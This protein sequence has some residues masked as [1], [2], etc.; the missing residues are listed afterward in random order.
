MFL[1]TQR[2]NASA[3]NLETLLNQERC[4]R[5]EDGSSETPLAKARAGKFVEVYKLLER[6]V[7][8][9]NDC[10]RKYTLLHQAVFWENRFGVVTLINFGA[11]V[12]CKTL[13]KDELLDLNSGSTPLHIAALLGNEAILRLL[14]CSGADP[15]VRDDCGLTPAQLN[16][17][18]ECRTVLQDTRLM[19][20]TRDMCNFA[21]VQ[22]INKALALSLE[23]RLPLDV[24]AYPGPQGSDF[25]IIHQVAFFGDLHNY[26]ILLAHGASPVLK[27]LGKDGGGRLLPSAVARRQNKVAE[28][29]EMEVEERRALAG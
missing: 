26:R 23:H 7:G 24:K 9:A 3:V 13:S 11:D 25:Y 6:G 29:R 21:K 17:S 15:T 1:L 22:Q 10:G 8:S 14:L 2:A 18:P 27:T 16:T 4:E 12:N 19:Q 28:S 20:L 5:I